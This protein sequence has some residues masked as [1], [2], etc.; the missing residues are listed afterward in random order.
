MSNIELF[1]DL[2]QH[3]LELTYSN[4]A[5][6]DALL[7]RTEMIARNTFG[8]SSKYLEDVKRLRF[9]PG[10]YPSSR[11]IYLSS[12]ESGKNQLVNLIST[13]EEELRLFPTPS[14][15]VKTQVTANDSCDVFV[16][17]GHDEAMK[18]SVARTL[19]ILNLNPL[20]L[21]EKPNTGRT[22]IEKFTDYA[23]VNF[24]IVLLSPD[25][26]GRPRNSDQIDE[27]TRARQ[28]VVFELGYFIGKLGRERVIALYRQEHNFEMPSDFSGVL[29]VP[30]DTQGRWQ[31]DIVKELKACGYELDANKLL[32]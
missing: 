2:K 18:Q 21:H 1:S 9:S 7:R 26:I 8:D 30:F 24:A 12:W 15:I 25:D 31:F 5:A 29:F 20:I 32:D 10:V 11:E 17:H 19:S 13:M 14:P 4:G 22:I 27:K 6:L 23:N 16:V 3:A 28:N